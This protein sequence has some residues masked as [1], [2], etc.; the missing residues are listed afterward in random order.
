[1][2]GRPRTLVLALASMLAAAPAMAQ[3]KSANRP[4]QDVA[5][6]LVKQAIT[7]SQ[8]GDHLAAIDL[9]LSAYTLIPQHALLSNV[10]NEYQQAGKPVEALKYFC[11]YLDKDPTG[12]NA[13]YATS[14]AK[15]LQIELGNKDI[16]DKDVCKPPRKG[17]KEPKQPKGPERPERP[18]RPEGQ[19]EKPEGVTGTV[20]LDKTPPGGDKPK[21]SSSAGGGYKLAGIVV[22]VVGLAGVG[23]GT[24]YGIKA[25]DRSDYITSYDTT[26]PWPDRIRDI[27]AEGQRYENYQLG[28]T[29]GGGVLTAAG[30]TLFIIGATK[31][32][33]AEKTEKM[34][35][36]PTATGDS[37]GLAIGRGF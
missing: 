9:Y 5:N 23:A 11:M 25:R 19:D 24:Y 13:T 36:R 30:V 4:P 28:L 20:D 12:T 32:S 18:E 31:S 34:T 35:V 26:M 17:G 3:P 29:I 2:P 21:P 1:M 10:G 27:Q 14:K 6:D 37:V 7:K 15:A 16:D 22:G 8:A 33:P